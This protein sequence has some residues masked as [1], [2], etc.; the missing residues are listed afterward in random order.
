M[1][2]AKMNENRLYKLLRICMDPQ[3]DFKGLLKN[4][5]GPVK[6]FGLNGRRLMYIHS[7]SANAVSASH[8]HPLLQPSKPSFA[9]AAPS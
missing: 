5:V 9:G 3:T 1:K 8:L 6:I 2:F 7:T 4:Y